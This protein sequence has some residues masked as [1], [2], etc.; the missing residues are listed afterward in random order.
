MELEALLRALP[1]PIFLA[2]PDLNLLCWSEQFRRATGRTDRQLIGL[3]LSELIHPEDGEAL[4]RAARAALE[5]PPAAAE[6]RLRSGDGYVPHCLRLNPVRD[7]AGTL[8]GLAGV[9]RDTAGERALAQRLE[10]LTT[11]DLLTGVSNRREIEARLGSEMGR[12]D[13]YGG[14]L[15]VLL[16]DIDRFKAVNDSGGHEAGDEL[17]RRLAQTVQEGI[18]A[19]DHMGRWSGGEF[20]VVAPEMDLGEATGFAVKLRRA[21]EAAG[22]GEPGPVTAS[23]GVAVYRPGEPLEA[24]VRRADD[25]LL[26]AKQR[27]RN[28]VETELH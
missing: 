8:L 23:F 17:L 16:F 14:N 3:G 13:R 28:R 4:A 22:F 27:G 10:E 1:D 26:L 25:A 21:I 6:L 12:V 2:D 18:R 11:I 24:L 20:M 5:D 15:S 19:S 9:A 7:T